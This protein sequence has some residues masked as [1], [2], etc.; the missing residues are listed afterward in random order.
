[1]PLDQKSEWGVGVGL[2]INSSTPVELSPNGI[3]GLQP[4]RAPGLMLHKKF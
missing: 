2:N 3:L 1:M 4:K